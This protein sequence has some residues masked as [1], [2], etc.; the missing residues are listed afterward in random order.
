MNKLD[1][2]GQGKG[3]SFANATKTETDFRYH[4]HDT[5]VLLGGKTE[6]ARLLV[7]AEEHGITKTDVDEVKKYN[8]TL[9]DHTK[10]RLENIQKTRIRKKEN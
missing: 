9:I 10:S 2:D 7:K 8:I 5:I 6:I 3:K 1:S 4:L